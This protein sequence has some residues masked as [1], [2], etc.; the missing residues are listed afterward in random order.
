MAQPL[1]RPY[2]PWQMRRFLMLGLMEFTP[3]ALQQ[4]LTTDIGVPVNRLREVI[5]DLLFHYCTRF[6]NHAIKWQ[7]DP[8]QN[9]IQ[10][11]MNWHNTW[12]GFPDD[13]PWAD[14]Q[15]KPVAYFMNIHYSN[16]LRE[17]RDRF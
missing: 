14:S 2:T 1:Y 3:A 13:E 11:M 9:P 16:R 7:D 6:F 5:Y 15:N 4:L 8:R 10:T 17:A 12:E